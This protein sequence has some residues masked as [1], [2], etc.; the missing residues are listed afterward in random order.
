MEQQVG[1]APPAEPDQGIEDVVLQGRADTAAVPLL[2]V[3]VAHGLML[4]L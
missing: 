4:H 3:W 2:G 1:G